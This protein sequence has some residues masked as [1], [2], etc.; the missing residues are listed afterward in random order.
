VSLKRYTKR[1]SRSVKDYAKRAGTG[2]KD[3]AKRVNRATAAERTI[4]SVYI[5]GVGA[6]VASYFGTGL[7]GAAVTA[8]GGEHTRRL[9]STAARDEG[10]SGREARDEGRKWRERA[11]LAG[12]IGT[13]AGGIAGIWGPGGYGEWLGLTGGAAA[14]EAPVGEG[15]AGA[16]VAGAGAESTGILGSGITWGGL[17]TAGQA[18]Y[19]GYQAYQG[20][21]APDGRQGAGEGAYSA[22]QDGAPPAGGAA[23]GSGEAGGD[24]WAVQGGA[25]APGAPGGGAGLAL[26]AAAFVVALAS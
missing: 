26:V 7:A 3:Y 25:R 15:F 21:Q 2:V 22:F 8:V 16:A 13:A 11:W 1:V 6:G 19:G 14:A 5:T 23:G 17:A 9:G 20:L 12:S 24:P 18:I 4:A 10:M